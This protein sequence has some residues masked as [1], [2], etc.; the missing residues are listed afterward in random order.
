MVVC[1]RFLEAP[2]R[3]AGVV[4]EVRPE[5]SELNTVCRDGLPYFGLLGF[6]VQ[7][8]CTVTGV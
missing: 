8:I 6:R 3:E 5:Y 4:V 7:Y 1:H 2:L